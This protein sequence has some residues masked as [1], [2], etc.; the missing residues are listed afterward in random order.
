[1]LCYDINNII[2]SFWHYPQ[3]RN[4]NFSNFIFIKTF[5]VET[6]ES[7]IDHAEL[8]GE[9]I[10]KIPSQRRNAIEYEWR[11]QHIVLSVIEDCSQYGAA[12]VVQERNTVDDSKEKPEEDQDHQRVNSYL[13]WN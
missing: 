9:I 5:H 4:F 3:C 10:K 6:R 7:S 12:L 13:G 2:S 8:K 1:M 11:G